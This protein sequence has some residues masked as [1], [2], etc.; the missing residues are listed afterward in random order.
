ML[1][2]RV[3]SAA[4]VLALSAGLI[5]VTST[6]A[7]AA[8]LPAPSAPVATSS[9]GSVALAWAA[10]DGATGYTLQVVTDPVNPSATLLHEASTAARA[11]VLPTTVSAATART[12]YWHVA[13]TYSGATGNYTDWTPLNRAALAAP[14]PVGPGSVEGGVVQFPQA[15]AFRW[16][17][18]PGAVQYRVEYSTDED[19]AS[20]VTSLSPTTATSLTPSDPLN[21]TSS[22]STV[23]WYW[24]V[25]A[26]F[27]G[28]T[29][30]VVGPYSDPL[31][32]RILW[33][34]KPTTQ[35][36]AAGS[37]QYSD[38]RFT[39][40]PV[41]GAASYK[42]ELASN[43]EFSGT[44]P[45][46][47]QTVYGT[48]WVPT[49]TLLSTDYYWRVTPIDGAGNPG[50]A[51]ST[52]MFTKFWGR[53]T[54]ESAPITDP[55][56]YPTPHQG[57]ADVQ[58]PELIPVDKFELSWDPLARATSYDVTV[59]PVNDNNPATPE[60]VLTCR[61]A[62]TSVTPIDTYTSG[63]GRPDVLQSVAT[64]FSNGGSERMLK[65]G[66]TY[67][68]S[69]TAYDYAGSST[70]AVQQAAP[71]GTVRSAESGPIDA[72]QPERARYIQIGAAV[73]TPTETVDLDEDSWTTAT[74]PA[75]QGQPSPVFD[76]AP[77]TGAAAYQV[78]VIL[79][80]GVTNQVAVFCTFG[81]R[82]RPNG[83][84][85]DNTTNQSYIWRVQAITGNCSNPGG[86][87]LPGW[88]A[89]RL[90]W[91]KLSKPTDFTDVTP[92]QELTDGT[93]LLRWRPQAASAPLDGG[94]RGYQVR[95]YNGSGNVVGTE[96]VEYPF[97]A[98]QNPST[99]KPLPK[100]DYTFT[101]APLDANGTPWKESDAQPFSIEAPAPVPT[102]AA[103]GASSALLTW[104]PVALTASY[105]VEWRPFGGSF[106]SDR[107]ATVKQ[108]AYSVP[109][110]APG[111]YQW[112]V[113]S[114]DSLASPIESK[115]SAIQTFEVVGAA[116][117]PATSDG[118]VLGSTTHTLAWS[119]VTGA[120]RY[121]VRIAESQ[122]GLAVATPIETIATTYT[123]TATM[124]NVQYWWNVSA[125]PEK[126]DS[127][128]TR[129]LLG[130][131]ASRS[132]T[133]VTPPKQPLSQS[134][135]ASGTTI[136]LTWY[137]LGAE[138]TGSPSEPTYDIQYRAVGSSG[139][140]GPWQTMSVAAGTTTKTITGLAVATTYDVA[141]RA[142]NPYGAGPW[143][144]NPSRVTTSSVLGVVGGPSASVQG[145]GVTLSWYAPSPGPNLAATGYRVRYRP[146]GSSTWTT[147]TLAANVTTTQ[148]T[149]LKPSTS[150]LIEIAAI[151]PVGVGE[152]WSV[153]VLTL[154]APSA[155]RSVTAA[156]GN[157]SAKVTWAAPSS[158]GGTPVTGYAVQT[159]YYA[160]G[161][162]SGWRTVSNPGAGTR[163]VT[164]TGL[165]NGRGYH[166]RVR[167]KNL[168][169]PNG[170]TA[171][172]VVGVTPLTKP[173][174]PGKVKAT[175]SLSKKIKVSW[176]KP[177]TNGSTLKGY[178]VRYS[179]DRKNWKTLKTIT[180]PG[181]LSY[182]WTA[183]KRK[184][185]YFFQVQAT[186]NV[187]SSKFSSYVLGVAT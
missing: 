101:V 69:V 97:Y 106:T 44:P 118:V 108:A 126:Q 185:A 161:A 58:N 14:E 49:K 30:L 9:G 150:Y 89:E 25:R 104:T 38:L 54:G 79:N 115:T 122:S 56:A 183:T 131:S 72:A 133:I 53:Q 76:W 125:V 137:K 8:T 121:V 162:W 113:R 74:A 1:R 80:T 6:P 154:G 155:P 32:F 5:H 93:V 91:T 92:T 173:G 94:S 46:E 2:S 88:S 11:Y 65:V 141:V 177:K 100:G 146:T 152:T 45:I 116:P 13:A 117:A 60:T 181:T 62:S 61:T 149:G 159:Q 66:R 37:I 33:S 57:T 114:M 175:T 151:N 128:P 166:V 103:A 169:A 85:S 134:A 109:D 148:V 68:W 90:S 123:P 147:R 36:P 178:V 71:V 63:S 17:P 70:T 59:T 99:K 132:F 73:G 98:A 120:S 28:K 107:S 184:K 82:L 174:A 142:R 158:T 78:E 27:Q 172:A 18:V 110:L 86:V 171:S 186:S 145:S 75:L 4:A 7:S 35:T 10:V 51:S 47:P 180:S 164:L 105:K 167:A 42:V 138:Y 157:A 19:F 160:S 165:V 136:N 29:G 84:F 143:P 20:N 43:P 67:A 95:I 22:G 144:S 96:K 16:K 48:T 64:C 119:A 55:E 52:V 24:H 156:R 140:D 130:T 81:T 182:T 26:E 87:L 135:Q 111:T 112:R 127:S 153:S 163:S 39:W 12:V 23:Q 102:A 40:T 21:R 77:V 3:V 34:Q 124:R 187:G 15:V 176:A 170:G 129:V 83:V 168:V 139:V 50:T 179:A 31:S 41:S